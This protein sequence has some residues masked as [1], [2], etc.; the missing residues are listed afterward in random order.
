[1]HQVLTE[2]RNEL[3]NIIARIPQVIGSD[4]PFGNVH[5]NWSFPGLN[6]SELVAEAQSIIEL[7]DERGLDEVSTGEAQIRDYVRRLQFIQQQTLPNLWGNAAL[8]VPAYM[9]TLDGLRKALNPALRQDDSVAAGERL[10]KVINAIRRMEAQIAGIEPRT[11]NI[12]SMLERIEQAFEAADQLPADLQTLTEAREKIAEALK[13]A[14]SEQ[15]KISEIREAADGVQAELMEHR[16]QAIAVLE[17]CESAYSASTSVGLGRAFAERSSA[18]NTSVI[19][20]VLGLAVS[21]GVGSWL[22]VDRLSKLS[23]LIQSPNVPPS[24]IVLNLL[25]SV[26]SVGAPVWF[27]WL[28]TKQIGQR[29]RLAEDYSY[30]ASVAQ[31][32]EGFR[33]ESARVDKEMEIR[34]LSSALTRLDELPGR[35][36]SNE[37]HGSPWHELASSD[38]VKQAMKVVPDFTSQVRG[39]A[40]QAIERAAKTTASQTQVVASGKPSGPVES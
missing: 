13:K 18:L 21:L 19:L 30:K 14:T 3:K 23:T 26:L 11:S 40:T 36:V 31:A 22:G 16:R 1:M 29:F 34:L 7:I 25:L 35:L 27:A 9:Y 17:K 32:Y 10:R 37:V 39:L 33:R 12:N 28:A 20:W 38:L 15:G 8:G 5:G 2:I 6:R 24:A 4:E